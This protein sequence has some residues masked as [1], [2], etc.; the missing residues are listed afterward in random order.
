MTPEWTPERLDE[1]GKRQGRAQA[2]ARR[3]RAGELKSDPYEQLSIEGGLRI[4]SI[5][6]SLFVSFAYG[7]SSNAALIY[8]LGSDKDVSNILELAQIPAF[9]L[10]LACI[11]SS[12]VSAIFLA[13]SKKRNGFVWAVKGLMGGPVAVLELSGLDELKTR[14]YE[15]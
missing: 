10:I 5:L 2:W 13:P 1:E 12:V 7:K 4:Y 6:T 15:S 11:G 8:L 9:A 3:A 14:G